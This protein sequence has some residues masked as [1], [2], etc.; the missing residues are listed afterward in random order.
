[1]QQSIGAKNQTDQPRDRNKAFA[2]T[3]C[4]SCCK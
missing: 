2:R 4:C 1:M 3:H